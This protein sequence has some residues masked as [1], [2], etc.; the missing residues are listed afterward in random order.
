MRLHLDTAVTG[1]AVSE[2]GESG[3][4]AAVGS[5][6]P[7]LD[8]TIGSSFP[9]DSI[10]ISGA[11]S[12]LNRLSTDRSLRLQQLT[13]SVQGGTYSFSGAQVSRALVEDAVSGA[14]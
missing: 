3:K 7:G 5:S 2:P 13:A 11:S 8:Q 6:R 12:A 10:Q 14:E 4:A 1:T 9:G